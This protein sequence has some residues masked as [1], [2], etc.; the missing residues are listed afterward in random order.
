MCLLPGGFVIA[1]PVS[2]AMTGRLAPNRGFRQLVAGADGKHLYGLEAGGWRQ[3]R[4]VKFDAATGQVVAEKSL[5]PDVRDLTA[6]RLPHQM[7]GRLDL[8]ATVP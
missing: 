8:V 2:G 4:M 1:D 7:E 3:V 6:G 5:E